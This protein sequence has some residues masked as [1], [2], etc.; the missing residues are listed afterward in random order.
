MF[1]VTYY[2]MNIYNRV[3]SSELYFDTEDKVFELELA[4]VNSTKNFYIRVYKDGKFFEELSNGK[5]IDKNFRNFFV[6]G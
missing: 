4:F 1:K 5:F 3:V 6:E 2:A